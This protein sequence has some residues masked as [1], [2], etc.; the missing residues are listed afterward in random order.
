MAL[1]FKVGEHS[2][3]S[4]VPKGFPKCGN[5]LSNLVDYTKDENEIDFH[6]GLPVVKY[7]V[8]V[9]TEKNDD[10][11]VFFNHWW[12]ISNNSYAS[13]DAVKFSSCF[14]LPIILSTVLL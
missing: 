6:Q 4:P 8:T 11:F 13:S 5:Y 1:I 2:D 3:F 10:S 7:N 9:E 12:P 14:L